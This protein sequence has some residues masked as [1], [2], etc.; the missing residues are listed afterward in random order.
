MV[1]LPETVE[2]LACHPIMVGRTGRLGCLGRPWWAVGALEIASEAIVR[3]F[4]PA[5]IAPQPEPGCLA[6]VRVN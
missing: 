2:R 4:G 6:I 3:V 5:A 1:C